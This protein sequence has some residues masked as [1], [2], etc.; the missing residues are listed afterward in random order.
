MT[1]PTT[2]ADG[3]R[4]RSLLG[5]GDGLVGLRDPNVGRS[6]ESGRTSLTCA[7]SPRLPSTDRGRLGWV[8]D[9]GPAVT[10]VSYALVLVLAVEL[11][12]W[13]AFL[14]PLRAF[15]IPLPVGPLIAIVANGA[16]GV[17]GCRVLHRR[18]GGVL[19]ELLW[20]AIALT[21]GTQRPEGDVVIP[22]GGMGLA[23]LVGGAVAAVIAVSAS[24]RRLP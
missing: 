22:G 4:L 20:L 7:T 13:G 1:D 5:V 18:L 9:R 8:S 21:L 19:P 14:V 17:A 10:A 15:G 11:A 2:P 23:Y 6:R 16:L 24:P 12:L 3:H